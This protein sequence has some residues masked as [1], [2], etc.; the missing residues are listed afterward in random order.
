[1]RTRLYLKLLGVNLAQQWFSLSIL[2]LKQLKIS[3]KEKSQCDNM[4]AKCILSNRQYMQILYMVLFIVIE[5]DY[6]RFP[7]VMTINTKLL[8]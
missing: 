1:M 2:R 7:S 5:R 3:V 6:V 8:F 4:V